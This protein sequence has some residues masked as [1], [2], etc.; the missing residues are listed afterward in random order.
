MHVCVQK[1]SSFLS[2]INWVCSYEMLTLWCSERNHGL[3]PVWILPPTFFQHILKKNHVSDTKLGSGSAKANKMWSLL[4]RNLEFSGEGKYIDVK[5][6]RICTSTVIEIDMGY[7]FGK[8]KE[9]M[10]LWGGRRLALG[11]ER[12]ELTSIWRS[13]DV[14]WVDQRRKC[15]CNQIEHKEICF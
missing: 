14:P 11:E 15:I 6:H 3:F 4:L 5:M 10:A 2:W 7:G 1:H 13:I 9:E 8:T 12:E